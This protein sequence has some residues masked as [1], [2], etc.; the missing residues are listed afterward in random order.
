RPAPFRPPRRRACSTDPDDPSIP[1][2]REGRVRQRNGRVPRWTVPRERGKRG[3]SVRVISW[4]EDGVLGLEKQVRTVPITLEGRILKPPP[5]C[6]A[7][8][9][10]LR[11]WKAPPTRSLERLRYV[12]H[13][14]QRA[15]S[16]GFPAARWW[17]F[18]DAP[19]LEE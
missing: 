11:S 7:K 15:G 14:F 19:T 1:D 9:H 8:G 16:G 3:A 4:V 18:Q 2:L 12:A 10:P 13:A 5:S 17:Y 6:A